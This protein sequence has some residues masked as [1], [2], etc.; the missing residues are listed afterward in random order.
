MWVDKGIREELPLL[1]FVEN[2]KICAKPE[3]IHESWHNITMTKQDII[4]KMKRVQY[5]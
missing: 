1:M 4:N 3:D 2:V 5:N